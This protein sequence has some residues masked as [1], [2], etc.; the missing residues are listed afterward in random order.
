M[1]DSKINPDREREQAVPSKDRKYEAM[2]SQRLVAT[3]SKSQH[4]YQTPG[5]REQ[6]QGLP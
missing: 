1:S 4:A 5:S 3:C 6:T 2:L